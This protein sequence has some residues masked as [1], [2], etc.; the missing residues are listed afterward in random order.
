MVVLIALA[1][2][3]V[4]STFFAAAGL[5]ALWFPALPLLAAAVYI[6]HLRRVVV[7]ERVAQ[8]RAAVARRSTRDMEQPRSSDP[9]QVRRSAPRPPTVLAPS[10][11]T[12]VPSTTVRVRPDHAPAEDER[13]WS[14]I[15]VPLPTYVTAPKAVRSHRIID[16][17]R[18]G[19]WTEAQKQAEEARLSAVAP[20]R[21]QVFDQV[22]AEEAVALVE[23]LADEERRAAGNP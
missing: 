1:S 23:R 15:E 14:P 18:P 9:T 7:A 22:A 19:E 13:P 17:T 5:L 10:T 16:L 12:I 11:P 6:T 21:D 20:S 4:L 2:T 3:L 8:A